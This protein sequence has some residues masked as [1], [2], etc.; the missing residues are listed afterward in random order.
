MGGAVICRVLSLGTPHQLA[1]FFAVWLG[2]THTPTH[3]MPPYLAS[4]N[5]WPKK[6]QPVSGCQP[7]TM[8]QHSSASVQTHSRHACAHADRHHSWTGNRVTARVGMITAAGQ[9]SF[10]DN[11][12]ENK[13][14]DI[15]R[16]ISLVEHGAHG[17]WLMI[18]NTHVSCKAATAAKTTTYIQ[19][20]A[21][22][23]SQVLL[24]LEIASSNHPLET[25]KHGNTVSQ[26]ASASAHSH[27][28][29]KH[30]AHQQGSH[31]LPQAVQHKVHHRS[32]P[33]HTSQLSG[34]V[35]NN[36]AARP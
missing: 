36:P 2:K 25:F 20:A 34:T 19:M 29:H 9:H 17:T 35:P 3:A 15:R 31:S 16:H 12:V 32:S 22:H 23:N 18:E 27:K 1:H 10:T 5:C 28:S 30:T 13:A 11:L 4:P 14:T 24:T 8:Q 33:T 7:L 6:L 21:P 26:S